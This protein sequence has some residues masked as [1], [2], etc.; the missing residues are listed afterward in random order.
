MVTGAEKQPEKQPEKQN[1]C[2]LGSD[3]ADDSTTAPLHHAK[4]QLA[5]NSRI[6]S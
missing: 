4:Q 6:A 3:D 5:T 1:C 2:A